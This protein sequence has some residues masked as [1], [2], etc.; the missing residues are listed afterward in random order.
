MYGTNHDERVWPEPHAFRP[1][2]FE[3]EAHDTFDLPA[4]GAGDYIEGHRCPG[5]ALTVALMAHALSLLTSSMTYDV[6]PQD[7]TIKKNRIPALP[8]SGFVLYDVRPRPRY[9]SV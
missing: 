1:Q 8:E 6:A 3:T 4:Q 2:R 5:D 7:L 9:S